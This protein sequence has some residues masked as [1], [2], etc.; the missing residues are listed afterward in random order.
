LGCASRRKT[1]KTLN[2]WVRGNE[3]DPIKKGSAFLL[4]GGKKLGGGRMG[5]EKFIKWAIAVG[6][7]APSEQWVDGIKG[8]EP[9]N[10]VR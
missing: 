5:S 8:G 1:N 7:G 10:K 4:C 3:K 9:P 6:R 2:Q